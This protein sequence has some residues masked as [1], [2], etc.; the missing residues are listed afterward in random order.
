MFVAPATGLYAFHFTLLSCGTTAAA[1]N[2]AQIMYENQCLQ[3]AH[4]DHHDDH[5]AYTAAEQRRTC[6]CTSDA[7]E[8]I[9]Q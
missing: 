7:W 9:Q 5:N 8:G 6:V 1:Y 2:Q 4:A 3:N